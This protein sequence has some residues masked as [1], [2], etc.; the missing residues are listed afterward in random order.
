MLMFG[1][2]TANAQPTISNTGVP[3]NINGSFQDALWQVSINNGANWNQAL[4]VLTP[5]GAWQPNTAAYSWISA[6]TSGSGGGGRYLFR[7]F[8][9]LTGYD[10]G[11][12]SLSFRCAID[13]T[14]TNA[15]FFSLNGA[16]Y[17]GTCGSQN[18]NF[19]LAALQTVTTG[20]TD[21]LNELR[22]AVNGD[23]QTDGL[24]VSNASISA[25][26]N[27]VPEPASVALVAMGLVGAAAVARK[28]KSN[29]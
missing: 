27:V 18:N 23:S 15:G 8:F 26:V 5:P 25:N 28:R 17:G 3:A 10:P 16:T 7:T 21:G 29:S 19:Q 11:T 20:F 4:K 9:D 14:P 2:G 13:N 24:L 22:F 6:T 1:V 12:A